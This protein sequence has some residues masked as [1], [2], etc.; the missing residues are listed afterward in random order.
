[1]RTNTY[2]VCKKW[3]NALSFI[4]FCERECLYKNENI[5]LTSFL[6]SWGHKFIWVVV[7]YLI[8]KI[9]SVFCTL[10]NFRNSITNGINNRKYIFC[11]FS[12]FT[13]SLVKLEVEV[14]P[15][16]ATVVKASF[17]VTT[18]FKHYTIDRLINEINKKL[19]E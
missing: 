13:E 5:I 9:I 4:G 14:I 2:F 3:C 11:T 16:F 1:M 12:G 6:V 17:L 18:V 7:F 10:Q 19:I 8:S 15:R